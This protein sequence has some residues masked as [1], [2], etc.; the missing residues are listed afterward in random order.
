MVLAAASMKVD[1]VTETSLAAQTL[2]HISATTWG[3]TER[4]CTEISNPLL[5]LMSH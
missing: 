4:N 5:H 3:S 2:A 1:D